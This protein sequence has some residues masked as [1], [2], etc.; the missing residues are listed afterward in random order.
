MLQ[1]GGSSDAYSNGAPGEWTSWK[2]ATPE[3]SF[4]GFS[5]QYEFVCTPE[6]Q[7]WVQEG[8]PQFGALVDVEA[9]ASTPFYN[10][11]QLCTSYKP[12]V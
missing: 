3:E 5:S 6:Q 2:K 9:S 1:Y 7:N 4:F 12:S 11:R 10:S 8:M